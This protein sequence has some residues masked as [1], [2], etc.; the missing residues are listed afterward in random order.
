MLRRSLKYAI[1]DSYI[2]RAVIHDRDCRVVRFR[3]CDIG[4]PDNGGITRFGTINFG[5][6]RR[7][8][9]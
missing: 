7:V 1:S 6:A 3:A 9:S 2:V 4:K 5:S 8:E